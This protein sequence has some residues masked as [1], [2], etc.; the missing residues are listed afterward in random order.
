MGILVVVPLLLLAHTVGL[1]R[2]PGETLGTGEGQ[3]R[4]EG[5]DRVP[6]A[7]MNKKAVS[8]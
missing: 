7:I 2:D 4:V 3:G 6:L 5:G 1:S 8:N